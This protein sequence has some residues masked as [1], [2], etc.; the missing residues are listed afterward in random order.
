M[1][2]VGRRFAAL[3]EVEVAGTTTTATAP[4]TVTGGVACEV[5]PGVA[6]DRE[7]LEAGFG[8]TFA[9]NDDGGTVE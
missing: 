5:A 3:A 4:V 6:K 8:L 7:D 2:C 1:L 9:I